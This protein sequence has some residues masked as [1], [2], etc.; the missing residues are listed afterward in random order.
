MKSANE[1]LPEIPPTA[2]LSDIVLKDVQAAL[3]ELPPPPIFTRQQNIL[4][5]PTGE[6]NILSYIA[7]RKK[8]LYSVP[9]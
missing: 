2:I 9:T 5:G 6:A 8:Y 3:D 4:P 1:K 7:K